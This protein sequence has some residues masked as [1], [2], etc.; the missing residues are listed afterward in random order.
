MTV[1]LSRRRRLLEPPDILIAFLQK[2]PGGVLVPAPQTLYLHN[3][4]DVDGVGVDSEDSAVRYEL[5]AVI[6]RTVMPRHFVSHVRTCVHGWLCCDDGA[7]TGTGD[8]G[9]PSTA[10]GFVYDRTP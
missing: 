1:C 2:S 7:V 10:F 9:N 5:V 4:G 6:H 8:S 3:C